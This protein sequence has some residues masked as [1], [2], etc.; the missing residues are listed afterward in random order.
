MKN[1]KHFAL[2]VL[3][4]APFMSECR[5]QFN[6]RDIIMDIQQNFYKFQNATSFLKQQGHNTDP[7]VLPAAVD[8]FASFINPNFSLF[9]FISLGGTTSF[10]SI[11]A[12]KAAYTGF[13]LFWNGWSQ[14][15]S[16][17]V[18]VESV[19]GTHCRKAFMTAGGGE[20]AALDCANPWEQLTISNWEIVWIWLDCGPRGANWYI[21][22]Y[23]E[24]G[25]RI[26]T[27]CPPD[28]ALTL[29]FAREFPCASIEATGA[30][31]P[32]CAAGTPAPGCPP[33]ALLT[34]K[35]AAKVVKTK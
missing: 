2:G 11:A 5:K 35:E 34:A 13:A 29:A 4:V 8:A 17:N 14:H 33:C 15:F 7:A 16:N 21:D 27:M 3:L 12:I 30:F 20:W 18:V 19:S 23:T 10:T 28:G 9:Q 24:Y 31:P 6:E 1:L 26:F 25:D 22:S 32:S